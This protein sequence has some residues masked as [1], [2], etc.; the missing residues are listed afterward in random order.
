MTKHSCI[1]C[2]QAYED[3]DPDDYY[4]PPCNKVR[5]EIAKDLD[6]KMATLKPKR[7]RRS[8]LAEYDASPKVRGF[9]QVK[10]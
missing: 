2:H 8:L 6:K 3:N 10:L 7:E 5:I 9:V 1:K 4:C